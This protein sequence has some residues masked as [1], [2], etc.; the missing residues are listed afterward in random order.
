MA[1]AREP[2]LPGFRGGPRDAVGPVGR[3]RCAARSGGPRPNSLRGLR[4][5]RSDKRP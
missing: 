5:L 2:W 3:L 1:F 4:P